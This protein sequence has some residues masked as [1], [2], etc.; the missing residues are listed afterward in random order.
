MTKS[1]H[2]TL[3]M[4]LF[5]LILISACSPKTVQQVSRLFPSI[6]EVEP[7]KTPF[8][9]V[10]PTPTKTLAPTPTL[11]PITDLIVWLDPSLPAALREQIH[12]PEGVRQAQTRLEANLQLGPLHG[13]G[14][15]Q[16]TWV[17]ALVTPFPSLVDDISLDEIQRAWRGEPGETFTS[18]L[19]LSEHT[20]AAFEARWGPPTGDRLKLTADSQL[21]DEAWS[22]QPSWALVPFEAIEPR[23]KVLHV[24]GLSLFDKGLALEQYPLTVWFGVSGQ[25]EPVNLLRQAMSGSGVA[26]FPVSNRDTNQMTV[27]VMSGVTAL[28]RATGYKMDTKGTTYPAQDI[29]DWLRN[30]DLTHISNEV[31]FN[32]DCPKANFADTSTMFCSRPEYIEL[33]DFIGADIIELSGNHNNDWGRTADTYSLDLYKQRGWAT[34]AGGSNLEAARQPAKLENNGNKLAFIGCNPAGP[35]GAWATADEPGA[36]PCGDYGWLLDSIRQLRAEGY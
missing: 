18:P 32:T 21:L 27:L 34:L 8:Q 25:P 26:L 33:L 4:L 19:L 24:N 16:T 22:N 9:P 1:R 12:L 30:A 23:W 35:P 20:R 28:A 13:N 6:A 7:T 17:Y 5:I 36:A 2:T 10:G 11:P 3:P 29:Q 15:W 14:E 31:S